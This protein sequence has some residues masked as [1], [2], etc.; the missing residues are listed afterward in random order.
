MGYFRDREKYT[1]ARIYVRFC[2][3]KCEKEIL[4]STNQYCS[5]KG[6]EKKNK[7]SWNRARKY[8]RGRTMTR[9]AKTKSLQ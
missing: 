9:G 6:D 8:Y 3:D 7:I 5:F 2:P 4:N 1:R